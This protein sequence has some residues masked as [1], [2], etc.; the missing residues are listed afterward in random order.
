MK[1]KLPINSQNG[2]STLELMIAFAIMVIVLSGAICSNFASQY[3]VIASETNNEAQYL[4]KTALEDFKGQAKADFY[5]A[6]STAFFSNDCISGKLCYV[7]KNSVTDISPCAKYVKSEV[8]WQVQGYGTS[9]TS[10]FAPLSNME[11]IVAVGGDCNLTE[12]LG[13]WSQIIASSTYN[14]SGNPTGID[15]LNGN[16]YVIIDSAP[17]L[18]IKPLNS[19]TIYDCLNCD[20]PYNAIDVARDVSTGNVYAYVAGTTTAQFQIVDVTDFEHPKLIVSAPLSEPH[21]EGWTIKYYGQ[22]IYIAT[23]Y[24]SPTTPEFFIFDVKNPLYPFQIASKRLNTSPY[25]MVVADR[26]FPDNSIYRFAF[27]A[28]SKPAHELMIFEVTNEANV[29]VAPISFISLPKGDCPTDLRATSLVISGNYLWV[30]SEH[31]ISNSHC[32][33]LD[34][35]FQID[36]S[37]PLNPFIVSSLKI[38]STITDMKISGNKIYM[39]VSN[40]ASAPLGGFVDIDENNVYVAKALSGTT[41]KIEVCDVTIGLSSC[42]TKDLGNQSL[43]I[44]QSL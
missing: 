19:N 27:V 20:G 1:E 37:N 23:R 15:V 13:N 42:V 18:Q 40:L 28:V 14:F 21:A 35:L 33:S 10:L 39:N 9:S 16:A 6:T 30:A 5:N 11:E 25:Q 12:V 2:F 31:N 36:I 38:A 32:I 8:S 22:K 43:Q 26:K 17:W 44:F 7:T 3:F 4:A 24:V 41:K 34:N 29:S